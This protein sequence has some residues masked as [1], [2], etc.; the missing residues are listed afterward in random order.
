L[1]TRL[2][3]PQVMASV[4]VLVGGDLDLG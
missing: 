3:L 1:S 2:Y 4:L